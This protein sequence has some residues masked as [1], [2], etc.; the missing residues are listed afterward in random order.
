MLI[1]ILAHFVECINVISRQRQAAASNHRRNPTASTHA[2]QQATTHA[3]GK[4]AVS[5]TSPKAYRHFLIF[6]TLV[7]HRIVK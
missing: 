5:A 3:R 1:K 2:Q 7:G 4:Q 6:F